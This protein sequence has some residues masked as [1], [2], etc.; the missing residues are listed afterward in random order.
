[1]TFAGVCFAYY[2][3]QK[4]MVKVAQR[5]NCLECQ[6]KGYWEGT[7]GEKNRCKICDGTGKLK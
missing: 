3:L 4:G 5:N 6:G 7:R 1:M 2:L